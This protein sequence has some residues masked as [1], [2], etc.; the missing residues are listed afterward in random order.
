MKTF[1]AFDTMSLHC[2]SGS[3][4][5]F[6]RLARESGFSFNLYRGRVDWAKIGAIDVDKIVRE[7]DLETLQD[8]LSSV[9]SCCLN[10]EYDLKVLDPNFVKIFQLA[11]LG[12]D[13][14]LY[15]RNYLDHCVTVM[16]EQLRVALQ[17][18]EHLQ[19][20]KQ[21]SAK[22]IS[23]LQ[24]K[25]KAKLKSAQPT[26]SSPLPMFKCLGCEKV[27]VGE[28]YLLAHQQRRHPELSG[29]ETP[30]STQAKEVENLQ[31]Q[32]HEL[33][34]RLHA[35]ED[36]LKQKQGSF[37][38]DISTLQ[39]MLQSEL[40]KIKSSISIPQIS[41]LESFETESPHLKPN[42]L[43]NRT[44]SGLEHASSGCQVDTPN[45]KNSASSDSSEQL[46]LMHEALQA[47]LRTQVEQK[48]DEIKLLR[49]QLQEQHHSHELGM[50]RKLEEMQ[51][52]HQADLDELR[53]SIPKNRGSGDY[54]ATQSL[55][56]VAVVEDTAPSSN[57][58]GTL[59]T[60]DKS[61]DTLDSLSKMNTM[62]SLTSSVINTNRSSLISEPSKST[63]VIESLIE[64][65][66][67]RAKE[68][69]AIQKEYVPPTYED[70]SSSSHTPSSPQLV[71]TYPPNMTMV[72]KNTSTTDLSP[73][74]MSENKDVPDQSKSMY[75]KSSTSGSG[76]SSES[77]STSYDSDSQSSNSEQHSFP[78]EDE[79]GALRMQLAP[80]VL[81]GLK[82][83]LMGLLNRRLR[84]LG[85]D[86]EWKSLPAA[87]FH[88]NMATVKH[89]ENIT[90]KN[91]PSYFAVQEA[92]LKEVDKRV[93]EC[94]KSQQTPSTSSGVKTKRASGSFS[95][96]ARIKSHVK[97]KL[98][99]SG[100][101]SPN[102]KLIKKSVRVSKPLEL[103][104]N[105]YSL[106][107]STSRGNSS[108]EY[109]VLQGM[110]LPV[111]NE[112]EIASSIEIGMEKTQPASE[113]SSSYLYENVEE[114]EKPGA[115]GFNT[116]VK[117][118]SRSMYANLSRNDLEIEKKETVL[119]PVVK[120]PSQ[121][122]TSTPIKSSVTT[123]S[124]PGAKKLT[125]ISSDAESISELESD[126]NDIMENTNE[127]P[128]AP[129]LKRSHT[130]LTTAEL[131]A[132]VAKFRQSTGQLNASQ[133]I[134]KSNLK[135]SLST[136]NIMK[137]KVVFRDEKDGKYRVT[138]ATCY[139]SA[140]S[141]AQYFFFQF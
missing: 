3:R 71:T 27:F 41:V 43:T 57:I 81:D 25:L 61:S 92:L 29:F 74:K 48:S 65:K 89:H 5:D 1:S 39:T 63:A 77:G 67:V 79:G 126:L 113:A 94:L 9:M 119:E 111:T 75:C 93:A 23:I 117:I 10:S 80:Q 19:N 110:T 115:S 51:R 11:Q 118:Y 22:E 134:V 103:V 46:K 37:V 73:S 12:A 108:H 13:F 88:S 38:P 45:E 128:P 2:D 54:I 36:A 100:Y 56:N 59:Q 96:F 28:H 40:Q 125:F 21:Q 31:Q 124:Q 83:D 47:A 8:V 32:V 49:Q 68:E 130:G 14:L 16:Q 95:I 15:C 91:Q 20:L 69:P 34:E 26:N 17:E 7:R 52:Q 6:P 87:S 102:S 78:K 121:L 129:L 70:S 116:D 30:T 112:G 135:S 62:E 127:K 99:H 132:N 58:R 64:S 97:S 131:L 133:S 123:S 42:Q 85:V 98:S 101:L 137:K 138:Y 139:S 107:P 53:L 114:K 120:Q 18:I 33:K 72:R 4:H 44:T 86:P 109:E 82:E 141:T 24:K 66:P 140:L 104:E 76:S 35:T 136:G 90:A 105:D 60:W 122:Q 50:Q 84:E 106:E 55:S